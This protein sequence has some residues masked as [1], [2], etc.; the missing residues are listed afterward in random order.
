M[1]RPTK[2]YTGVE[3]ALFPAMLNVPS[4]ESSPTPSSLP[5]R[6]T[7]SP[8]QSSKPSYEPQPT[9]TAAPTTSEPQPTQSSPAAE[10]HVPT[11]HDSPLHSVPTHGSDEGNLQKTKKTY[12]TALTKLILK[13]KKLEKQV[14][15]GKSKE[16]SKDYTYLAQDDGVEWVQEADAEVQDKAN[17]ETEPIL[18][19]ETPTEVIH[20]Q[21]SGEKGQPEVSTAGILVSTASATTG[22]ASE[23]PIVSTANINVSTASTIHSEIQSTAGRVVYS[24]RSDETRKDKGK[25]IMT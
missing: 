2:G 23:T 21:G 6:I 7:S 18:Q 17:N 9:S 1:K 12:S 5:S 25:A 11:P 13:V 3:V 14:K 19:E 15:I 24:R 8:S 20:D 4:P 10:E 16:K 22:T